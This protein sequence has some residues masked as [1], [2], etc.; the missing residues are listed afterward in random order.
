[1]KRS[2][3]VAGAVVAAA[4]AALSA[5]AQE[6]NIYINGGYTQFDG[7]NVDLG[8]ITGRVGVGFGP[9]FGVEGEASFGVDDDGGIELDNELGLFGFGK[10]PVSERFELFARLGY[11][12]IETSPGGDNDGW[13]YG[14]GGQFF[15]TSVDGVRADFTRHDLDNG[16]EVDAYSVSY[17]RKF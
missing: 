10:V 15:F 9:Y 7:N 14:V 17:V 13:A 4:S 1:M 3:L 5:Q 12:Q 16:G 6:A 8:A 11:S 2:V